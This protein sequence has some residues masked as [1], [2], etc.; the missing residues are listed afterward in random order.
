[1]HIHTERCAQ[2]GI[3]SFTALPARASSP[4][5]TRAALASSF[6]GRYS[7]SHVGA[8]PP[9]DKLAATEAAAL[10]SCSA[11]CTLRLTSSISSLCVLWV[12]H[13]QDMRH[14]LR[15]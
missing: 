9:A 14:E 3:A 1:M 13:T 2:M 10:R 11:G 8:G 7:P 15:M 6:K 5:V 12:A 4:S